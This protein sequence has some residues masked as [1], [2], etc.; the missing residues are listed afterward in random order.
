MNRK[1]IIIITATL[2]TALIP[3]FSWSLTRP[4]VPAQK[5]SASVNAV[6]VNVSGCGELY[7][8][9]GKNMEFCLDGG[10]DSMNKACKVQNGE[11]MS[12]SSIITRGLIPR[13]ADGWY[14]DGFYNSGGKKITSIKQT[15]IDILRVKKMNMITMT[16]FRREKA[17][18]PI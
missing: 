12:L 16:I 4:S 9:Y 17:R 1:H 13:A 3:F 7:W 14:F 15:P 6:T 5:A 18:K 8:N 11:S 2:I 10:W